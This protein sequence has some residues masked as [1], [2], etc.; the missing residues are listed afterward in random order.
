MVVARKSDFMNH[1]KNRE[2]RAAEG[3]GSA[4]KGMSYKRRTGT[5]DGHQ[6]PRHEG[7]RGIA[8]LGAR[9]HRLRR[10]HK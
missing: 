5:D 1:K 8:R 3:R 2:S 6:T 10:L 4:K 7:V 9:C